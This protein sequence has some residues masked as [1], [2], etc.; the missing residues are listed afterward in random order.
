MD[1]EAQFSDDISALWGP[2]DTGLLVPAP[3]HR[4][5][6]D[7]NDD[8][9]DRRLAALEDAVARR[10][11]EVDGQLA[12]I[13]DRVAALEMRLVRLGELLA[14]HRVQSAMSWELESLR[15][16]LLAELRAEGGTDGQRLEPTWQQSM[17]GF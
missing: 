5:Q 13:T 1:D 6:A 8:G 7:D 17:P 4:A 16:E 9:V 2:E 14:S 12:A 10:G 3:V 11:A 15:S